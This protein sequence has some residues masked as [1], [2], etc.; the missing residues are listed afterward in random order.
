MQD[1]DE[2]VGEVPAKEEPKASSG[3]KNAWSIIRRFPISESSYDKV[4]K[5]VKLHK[6]GPKK[7][8]L[9]GKQFGW[10]HAAPLKLG[11]GKHG[12]IRLLAQEKGVWKTVIPKEHV[13]KFCR[14]AILNPE[15]KVPL[16]RDA[17]YHIVQKDCIGV[18]PR[19]AGSVAGD[20]EPDARDEETR[21]TP[22]KER[23]ARA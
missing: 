14:N 15:S 2:K 4:Q 6:K 13:E 3:Q 10:A 11:K 1:E 8:E 16:S 21:A 5:F 22:R 7:G 20:A 9:P 18:S 17:G 12:K 23:L 19:E